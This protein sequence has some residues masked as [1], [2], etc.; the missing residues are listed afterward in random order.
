MQRSIHS[1]TKERFDAL[2]EEINALKR[3]GVRSNSI[4]AAV[5]SIKDDD[6]ESASIMDP[7]GRGARAVIHMGPTKT[8]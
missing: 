2:T 1:A 3:D 6:G 8:G 5:N 7:V 4:T